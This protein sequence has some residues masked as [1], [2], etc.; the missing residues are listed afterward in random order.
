[1]DRI[2]GTEKV[3][4]TDG[5]WSQATRRGKMLFVSGQVSL[6]SNGELVGKDDFA[7]QAKQCLDNL[8]AMLEAGGASVKDLAV[9]TVFVTDMKNRPAFAQIRKEYFQKDP[10]ASTIVEIN[11]LFADEILIEINGIAVLD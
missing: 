1:M 3:A 7:V 9:I 6:D 4:A 11:R 8:V 10:P 2:I 5:T